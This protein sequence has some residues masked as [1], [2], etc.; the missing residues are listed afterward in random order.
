MFN[1]RTDVVEID[2]TLYKGKRKYNVGKLSNQVWVLGIKARG[3]KDVFLKILKCRKS[4]YLARTIKRI[5][6][7]RVK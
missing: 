6:H 2:E 3:K 5:V 7:P 1:K 4:V